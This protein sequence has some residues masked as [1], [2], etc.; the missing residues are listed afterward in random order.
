MSRRSEYAEKT[1]ALI[2]EAVNDGRIP[3]LLLHACCAP[4]SSYV[5]EY[6]SRYFAITIFYYNPNIHPQEEYLRRLE[7]QTRLCAAL[8]VPMVPC[9]YDPEVPSGTRVHGAAR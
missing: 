1:D 5:I 7:E 9:S 6:L 4:C 8:G 3:T 2:A